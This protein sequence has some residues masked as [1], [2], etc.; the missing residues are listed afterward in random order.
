MRNY[1]ITLDIS[2]FFC[3]VKKF[4]F[5]EYNEPFLYI[6]TQASDPDDVCY[7]LVQDLISKI[8]RRDDSIEAR[9]LCRR[10]RRTC[11]FDRIEQL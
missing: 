11:R 10:I 4:N 9:I 6:F 8:L 5:R 7:E 2:D 1:K 3:E